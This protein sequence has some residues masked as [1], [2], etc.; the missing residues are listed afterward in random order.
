MVPYI[1]GLVT[2]VTDAW[3]LAGAADVDMLDG[4]LIVH[5][6]FGDGRLEGIQVH[7]HQ[8]DHANAV[9]LGVLHVTGEVTTRKQAA[10]HLGM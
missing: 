9:V 6:W 10:V 2:T 8:I 7:D 5:V 3:F 4:V 1:A